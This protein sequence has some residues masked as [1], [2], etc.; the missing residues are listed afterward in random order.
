MGGKKTKAKKT[1]KKGK[2]KEQQCKNTGNTI[3][4]CVFH[5]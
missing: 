2:Q 1:G 4:L 5:I 3:S